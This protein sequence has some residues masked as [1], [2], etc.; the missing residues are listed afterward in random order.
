MAGGRG[1]AQVLLVATLV[2]SCAHAAAQ[3]G[4]PK[5]PLPLRIAALGEACPPDEPEGARAAAAFPEIEIRC[6]THHRVSIVMLG[7]YTAVTGKRLGSG[8]AYEFSD[9]PLFPK[10]PEGRMTLPRRASSAWSRSRGFRRQVDEITVYA[11]GWRLW[12][13][14]VH[15]VAEQFPTAALTIF[16]RRYLTPADEARLREGLGVPGNVALDDDEALSR[17]LAKLPLA[18]AGTR[19]RSRTLRLF[20]RCA[21]RLARSAA[22]SDVPPSPGLLA[23]QLPQA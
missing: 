4:P 13:R 6:G 21:R 22:P 14:G 2:A 5:T 9:D 11:D 12:V 20:R 23:Q 19:R 7:D 18:A 8:A 16:D 15:E 1:G 17:A 10:T 3:L